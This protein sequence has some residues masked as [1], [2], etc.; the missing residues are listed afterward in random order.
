MRSVETIIVGGGPAGSSCA[1]ELMHARK[2]CLLLEATAMPRLK[3]CAG[4]VTPKV[5]SDL[6][7]QPKDYPKGIVTLKRM[8]FFIGKKRR[9]SL[10]VPTLQ[11][12]IR[13]VEFDHW[14]L[15]RSGVEV[16]RHPVKKIERRAGNYVIDGEFECRFLVG[17]GGSGCPVQKTF[18][19][20]LNGDRILTKEIEYPNEQSKADCT[21]WIPYAG[22]GYAWHIPKADAIN[23][24]YGCTSTSVE[25]SSLNQQW[26][27]FTELL[28]STQ[29]IEQD[30]PTPSGWFY[31]LRSEDEKKEVK[32]D[33]AYI[34]G[35]AVGLATRDMGEGIGP[36]VESGILAARDILGKG[37]YSLNEVTAYS[38]PGL[39]R[40]PSWVTTPLLRVL[41]IFL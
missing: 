30:C 5:L 40:L 17:A 34:V 11:Y 41:A 13:R 26:E 28:R 10:N 31:H 14:L 19:K 8:R 35:D 2:E 15:K 33:N 7:I 36:A 29:H 3:L 1:R 21:L 6:E 16:I 4:W 23:I 20:N 12:S 22:R 38:L 25:P 37:T 39:L 27:D 9:L 18:F 24:G 32:R